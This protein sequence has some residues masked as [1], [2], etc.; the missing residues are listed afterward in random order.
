SY[1]AFSALAV[2]VAICSR[3]LCASPGSALAAGS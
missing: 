2:I 3:R 1:G